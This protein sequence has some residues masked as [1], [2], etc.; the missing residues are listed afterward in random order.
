MAADNGRRSRS[1]GF[2]KDLN[3]LNTTGYFDGKARKKGKLY[4]VERVIYA[5]NTNRKVS[6]KNENNSLYYMFIVLI[7]KVYLLHNIFL[8][9]K[10]SPKCMITEN[11]KNYLHA[12]SL[13][14]MY[15]TFIV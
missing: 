14:V 11:F 5:R 3:N 2:Y 13:V 12:T 6:F 15:N 7:T 4:E 10:I 9:A 1:V 8:K